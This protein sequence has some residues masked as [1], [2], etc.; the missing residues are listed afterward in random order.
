MAAPL[1]SIVILNYNTRDLLIAC[2]ES[3]QT[4]VA[5]CEIIVVDNASTDQSALIV[6]QKF[7]A[8]E[9]IVSPENC[10]FARGMN[11]GLRAVTAPW[12]LALN[13]DTTLRFDTLPP[14]MQAMSQLPDAGIVGPVQYLPAV[15]DRLGPQLASVFPDPTLL[16]EAGRLL[17]F[18]DSLLA[19]L[20]RGAWRS[21]PPGPPRR[22]AW[23]MGAALLFRR[24]CLTDLEGFD[25]NQFMYGEDWDICYRARRA[26]WQV[27]LVPEAKIFHHEN[28]A[29]KKHFA[30]N[31]LAAVLRAN[32]Y[33]H[34]K[35]YG[36]VSRRMLAGLNLIGA[37]LRLMLLL[38]RQA[39]GR[40]APAYVAR[41]QA[42]LQ[43][44]RVAWRGLL[45]SAM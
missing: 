22:V 3:I 30:S 18:S 2:L 26:G 7:P 42:Q 10:G 34:Q 21:E 14:L 6:Q 11:V 28:A 5:D 33:F 45:H 1:V 13:A 17:L 8:V 16:R 29:G 4:Y 43:V 44:A 20:K 32:L 9:L 23:L 40:S 38:P 35:H 19:R 36:Q 41:W 27:Y 25:E 39:I 31:R 24:E 15:A 12:I 37:G